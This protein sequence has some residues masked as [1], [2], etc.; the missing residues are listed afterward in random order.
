M[1]RKKSVLA[2]G[3]A[4]AMFALTF[5]C[6]P[7]ASAATVKIV[8]N[9]N[10][11]T[12]G[13]SAQAGLV[14]DSRG[15]LYGTTY[16]FGP[17][18]G[19]TVFEFT[20]ISSGFNSGLHVLHSFPIFGSE[21]WGS[22]APVIFDSAGALYTTMSLV[23]DSGPGGT[24]VQLKPNTD[25]TWTEATLYVFSGGWDGAV[26]AAGLVLDRAGRLYGTTSAG[27]AHGNG[28]VF[29]LST[30]SVAGFVVLHSF[31]GSDG[32]SPNGALVFDA[33]GNLYGTT[34]VGGAYGAG[35]VFK[36]KPNRGGVGWTET[37]LHSFTGGTDGGDPNGGL[38]FDAA[39]NL[40][41]LAQT[42]GSAGNGTVFQLTPNADGSWSQSVIYAFQGPPN[43]GAFPAG[44]LTFDHAGNMYGVTGFNGS[45][46]TVFKLTPSTGGHWTET[47]LGTLRGNFFGVNGGLA[48]DG[49]GNLYGTNY[50]DGG[51]GYIFEVTP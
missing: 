8:H 6:A 30:T 4:I 51:E 26:P 10:V 13:G 45:P 49:A 33:S 14:L 39:G 27:G 31:T 28:V 24:V 35:T 37:V 18:D 40:Y 5:T 12:D 7:C 2:N 11:F 3:I 43:D 46:E 32:S 9:F 22:R 47:V 48:I 20:P 19:G 1:N 29:S 41:G 16:A 15:S 42:G 25:G 44:P 38:V 36:L 34:A 17:E 23:G 50:G 21:G